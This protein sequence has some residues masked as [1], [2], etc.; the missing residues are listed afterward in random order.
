MSNVDRAENL[1]F[2]KMAAGTYTAR[3]IANS[4]DRAGL[5]ARE[6]AQL[7]R[8]K[9]WR[10]KEGGG[11]IVWTAPGARIMVQ[12]LEPGDLTPHDARKLAHMLKR[13]AD[14]SDGGDLMTAPLPWEK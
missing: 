11:P 6:D 10:F 1:I 2:Q 4:L 5:I 3:G 12:R 9:E 14:Y 13:A 8:I 7:S